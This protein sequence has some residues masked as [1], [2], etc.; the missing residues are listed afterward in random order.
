MM[1]WDVG[2][3]THVKSALVRINKSCIEQGCTPSSVVVPA[4]GWA[5]YGKK[6]GCD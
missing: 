2:D 1:L 6:S 5:W 3:R 4:E